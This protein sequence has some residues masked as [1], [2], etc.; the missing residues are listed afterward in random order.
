MD[1]KKGFEL[2]KTP[3][4]WKEKALH[5]RKNEQIKITHSATN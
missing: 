1:I 2:I 3:D 5:H 4:D